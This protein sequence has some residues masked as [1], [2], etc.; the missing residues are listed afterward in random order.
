MPNSKAISHLSQI[1][2]WPRVSHSEESVTSNDTAPLV[3]R[4]KPNA[5]LFDPDHL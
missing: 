3:A 4:S 2:S 1:S 5:H